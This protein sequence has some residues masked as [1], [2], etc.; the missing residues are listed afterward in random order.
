MKTFLNLNFK[1]TQYQVELYVAFME[2]AVNIC[3]V[4]GNISFIVPNSWLK[5][6]MMSDCRKFMAENLNLITIIPNLE[7]VFTE[8]SVDTMIFIGVKNILNLDNEIFIDEFINQNLQTKHKVKQ[9]RFLS[10]KN[11]LF[12]VEVNDAILPILEKMNT[13]II[14]IGELFDVTRGV[15][16]YDRNTGQSAET[17]STRAYHSNIKQD[18]TFVPELKGMHASR[19]SYSWD[20]KHYIVVP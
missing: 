7:N 12:D 20:K 19:Y 3:K 6:M 10:N 16:P 8:A 15:N 13:D 5:N 18:E 4:N 9:A 11:Y 1:T 14:S 2:Q 17:I